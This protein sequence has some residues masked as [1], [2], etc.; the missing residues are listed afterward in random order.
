MLAFYF[1]RIP[2]KEIACIMLTYVHL[3][4]WCLFFCG[5]EKRGKKLQEDV[6]CWWKD[7]CVVLSA[8][9]SCF[10]IPTMQPWGKVEDAMGGGELRNINFFS[11]WLSSSC[12]GMLYLMWSLKKKKKLRTLSLGFLGRPNQFNLVIKDWFVWYNK[13]HESGFSE[14]N[15]MILVTCFWSELKC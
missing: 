5:S 13:Q 14:W 1:G 11:C 4:Y 3:S 6:C 9:N 8:L 7:F 10:Y 12:V 15:S 2:F